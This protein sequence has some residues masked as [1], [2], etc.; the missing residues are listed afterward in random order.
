MANAGQDGLVQVNKHRKVKRLQ[1][2]NILNRALSQPG[3]VFLCFCNIQL[4][5]NAERA[6]IG[7]ITCPESI[8]LCRLLAGHI[9]VWFDEH[10]DDFRLEAI[11]GALLCTCYCEWKRFEGEL[12]VQEWNELEKISS[13]DTWK[14]VLGTRQR[15]DNM[16][17]RVHKL[18]SILSFL[19][20]GEQPRV[21]YIVAEDEASWEKLWRGKREVIG[22]TLEAALQKTCI[23]ENQLREWK[24]KLDSLADN[25][26]L[27]TRAY[28]A[29]MWSLD[30]IATIMSVCFAVFGMFSQF[31]GY[32]VQLP[33]Y[34]MGNA[35]QYYFYGVMGGIV[36]GLSI[37]VY[38]STRWFL[39]HF[40]QVF[41]Y[42]G[43][44][45]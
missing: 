4:L 23:V 25:Y 26:S 19:Y 44:G 41:C 34:N 15:V 35:S 22:Y 17:Q 32:Y 9:A 8:E 30:L 37:S 16:L 18:T 5:V 2:D 6:I 11:L 31:F 27:G 29:R 45:Q 14:L 42:D 10:L 36:T 1:E 3:D 24:K 39:R 28:D 7:N 38:F 43:T 40:S 12:G 13:L 21:D 20:S 33:I